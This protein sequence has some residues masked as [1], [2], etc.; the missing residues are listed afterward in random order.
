MKPLHQYIR[1]SKIFT[2]YITFSIIVGWQLS[3]NI[4]KA[5][6]FHFL[7]TECLSSLSTYHIVISNIAE[8][9]QAFIIMICISYIQH[10]IVMASQLKY[11]KKLQLQYFLEHELLCSSQTYCTVIADIAETHQAFII[12]FCIS[13]IQ[14]HNY[15]DGI[16]GTLSYKAAV[17]LFLEL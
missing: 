8:I 1:L 15:C 11:H 4:I 16:S 9:H 5:S 2:V 14:Q 6:S 12:I 7:E 3:R 10:H 17:T 13:Y